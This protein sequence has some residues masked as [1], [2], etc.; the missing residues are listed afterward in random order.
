MS[1]LTIRLSILVLFLAKCQAEEPLEGANPVPIVLW[2]GMGDNCC[3]P[4]SM[5]RLKTLLEE[6][7][8]GVHVHSLMIGNRFASQL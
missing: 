6:Q 5:G 4:F 7:I 3:N 8:P 1:Y 2:H